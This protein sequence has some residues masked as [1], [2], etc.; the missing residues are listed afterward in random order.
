MPA[1]PD[2]A[3]GPGDGGAQK[4]TA[5]DAI[6]DLLKLIVATVALVYIAGGAVLWVRLTKEGVPTDPV[7]SALPREFLISVGLKSIVAP[8]LLFAVAAGALVWANSG[9]TKAQTAKLIVTFAVFLAFILLM[10]L[11]ALNRE[12]W[13]LGLLVGSVV[14]VLMAAVLYRLIDP[15]RT[16]MQVTLVIVATGIG[17]ASARVLV[18]IFD[19]RS[20]PATVCVKDS[21]EAFEGEYIGETDKTIYLAYPQ[22]DSLLSI[23]KD[24]VAETHIA[25]GEES[26]T[27]RLTYPLPQPPAAG[28]Q[29][30]A[31]GN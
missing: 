30:P 3:N 13:T 26:P 22:E 24:R 12:W 27:C 29:P 20:A 10:S 15:T 11:Y 16:A 2:A 1:V 28:S 25:R 19:H 14:A 9:G 23:P 31:P 5:V 6:A 8:A 18:E 21:S 17:G 7:V 4:P